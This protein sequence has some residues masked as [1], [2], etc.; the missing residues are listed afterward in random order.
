MAMDRDSA[1]YC[2]NQLPLHKLSFHEK[3]SNDNAEAPILIGK[4]SA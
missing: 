3:A 1:S 2:S 4:I